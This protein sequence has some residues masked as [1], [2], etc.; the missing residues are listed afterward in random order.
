MHTFSELLERLYF[1]NS[2]K[3]KTAVLHQY[4][5]QTPDPDRGWAI[6]AIAGTLSFDLFKRALI[7]ELILERVD[8]TLFSLSYDYVGEMSETVAHLWPT[9]T[10]ETTQN[11]CPALV[12]SLTFLNRRVSQTLRI[13]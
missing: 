4:L 12:K 6:A 3:T 9:F 5:K 10:T 1:T 11:L 13:T 8:E 7:K 2:T